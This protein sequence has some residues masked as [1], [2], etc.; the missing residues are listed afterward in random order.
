MSQL[1]YMDIPGC[2]PGHTKAGAAMD[3]M[4]P[5]LRQNAKATAS[6]AYFYRKQ[7]ALDECYHSLGWSGTLQDAKLMADAQLLMGIRYLV[8]HGF[9]YSTHGL[10]KHDAP[11]TF[12]F[13]A[14]YWPLFG[15]LSRRVERIAALFENT[16][17][18]AHMAVVEP[19]S[20]IPSQEDLD[21][22][23]RLQALLT[24][25]HLDFHFVDTDIL[26]GGHVHAGSLHIA[27]LDIGLIIVPPMQVVEPPLADWLAAFERSGG[28]VIRCRADFQER[29]V[30]AAVLA[31]AQPSLHAT[32]AGKEAQELQ[33]VK[34]CGHGRT[35]WFVVNTSDRRLATRFFAGGPLREL[36]LE[37][38]TTPRLLSEGGVY[39]REVYPF[40][41]FMLEACAAEAGALHVP[42]LPRISIALR[43]PPRL[44]PLNRN[45][46]R[47]AEWRMSLLDEAGQVAQTANVPAV[48]L[49]DQLEQ[50]GFRFAP[51]VRK[52][53]GRGPELD[54]PP[55]DV[56]YRF[57][58]ENH[59]SGG[60]ELVME[61]GSI[62]GAWALRINDGPSL[63][64]ADFAPTPTHVRGSLGADIAAYLRL[65]PI[66]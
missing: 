1:R 39:R 38:S 14:P 47:M 37:P 61:P 8:P 53:F 50:G 26:Q 15:E 65:A 16:H 22:Y 3:L 12:F 63:A 35:L 64:A 48:P 42:P 41:G 19:S 52:Y 46:L 7:G 29:D 10:R 49:S 34:R 27:D 11:P 55:L 32:V 21:A 40:E 56:R 43:G 18:D 57:S 60:V 66:R 24:Q 25:N 31:A 30:L 2:E 4:Q 51:M 5:Y 9:F 62:V 36:P 20:G 59:T 44:R 13:Q 17:I 6:A 54:W 45:L 58:F 33:I 23:S 28:R